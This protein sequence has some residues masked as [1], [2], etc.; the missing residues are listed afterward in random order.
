[1]INW[2]KTLFTDTAA[3]ERR[4]NALQLMQEAYNNAEQARL[5]IK[6]ATTNPEDDY[7]QEDVLDFLR[8]MDDCLARIQHNSVSSAAFITANN[9]VELVESLQE[10]I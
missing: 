2:V 8:D 7:S 3:Q 4:W 5:A 1:M 10:F 6:F 9:D